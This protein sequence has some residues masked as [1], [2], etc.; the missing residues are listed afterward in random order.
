MLV[1]ACRSCRAP[2][3]WERTKSGKA[4]PLDVEPNDGGNV[5]LVDGVAQVLGPID[6]ALLAADAVRYMPHHATCAS[7]DEWRNR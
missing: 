5:V 1:S 7:V 3:R 2:I 4:I 6:V